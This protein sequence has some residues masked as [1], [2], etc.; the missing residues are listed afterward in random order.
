MVLS[1]L[2]KSVIQGLPLLLTTLLATHFSFIML[3]VMPENLVSD[4]LDATLN[5]YTTPLFTQNWHLFSPNPLTENIIVHMQVKVKDSPTPSD[6]LDITTPLLQK[7]YQNYF[8]PIN[9]VA[10]IPFTAASEMR[11]PLRESELN[12][13]TSLDRE[14]MSKEQQALLQQ[15]EKKK[16]K[17]EES[18]KAILYRFAF[19]SAEQYFS[20]QKVD[21]LRLRIVTVKPLPLSDGLKKEKHP[22]KKRTY[23]EFEWRKFTPI[24]LR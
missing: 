7:N 24:L 2:K 6:W 10:R 16:V 15:I 13:L 3:H 5:S 17:N 11:N 1:K 18:M 21:S 19:A 20:S 9:R 23:Q 14:H 12:F 4:R 8:S 22:E